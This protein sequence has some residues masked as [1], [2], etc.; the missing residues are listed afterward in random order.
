MRSKFDNYGV[1]LNIKQGY[2]LV[3]YYVMDVQFFSPQK[4]CAG[5]VGNY[6]KYRSSYLKF[7]FTTKINT[8]NKLKIRYLTNNM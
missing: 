6:E 2:W 8:K 5:K 1:Y 4:E 7:G 3:V